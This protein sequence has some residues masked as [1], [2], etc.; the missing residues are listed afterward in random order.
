MYIPDSPVPLIKSSPPIPENF[1]IDPVSLNPVKTRSAWW[2]GIEQG[3]II[4]SLKLRSVLASIAYRRTDCD[5]SV[6]V[7]QRDDVQI[8][9]PIHAEEPFL[10]SHSKFAI[11]G[12]K[13]ELAFYFNPHE[14][15]WLL[16]I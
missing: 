9:A 8:M 3:P 12:V 1:E 4:W 10:S 2:Y 7:Y 14:E 6:Y 13:S 11:Q 15:N 16:E 5:Y